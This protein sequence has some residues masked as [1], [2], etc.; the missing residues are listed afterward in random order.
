MGCSKQGYMGGTLVSLP[1]G[2]INRILSVRGAMHPAG[3]PLGFSAAK[4][5]L[6]A[7]GA[8]VPEIMN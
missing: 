7:S 6:V 1:V 3:D 8:E 4:R 2:S 5:L